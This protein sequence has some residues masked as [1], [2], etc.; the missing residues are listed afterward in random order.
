MPLTEET[1]DPA[2]DEFAVDEAKPALWWQP[3]GVSPELPIQKILEQTI[4]R[5][6]RDQAPDKQGQSE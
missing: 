5:P 4:Q 2:M 6:W 3:V 1:V